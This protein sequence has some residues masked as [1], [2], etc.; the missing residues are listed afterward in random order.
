MDALVRPNPFI[1]KVQFTIAF[2]VLINALWMALVIKTSIASDI[3]ASWLQV[4]CV[5]TVHRRA[6]KKIIQVTP[7][8][9]RQ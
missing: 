8:G 4:P 2:G 5:L 7:Q 6:Y 9:R 1:I 3:F